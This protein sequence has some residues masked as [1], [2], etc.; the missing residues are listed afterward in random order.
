MTREITRWCEITASAPCS[1]DSRILSCFSSL[2][3]MCATIT[4]LRGLQTRHRI[5]LRRCGGPLGC[6]KA[7]AQGRG[8]ALFFL[9]VHAPYFPGEFLGG[10]APRAGSLGGQRV[11]NC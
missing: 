5:T 7:S 8:S 9:A 6:S 4:L 3:E 11:R 10:S 1:N 2:R